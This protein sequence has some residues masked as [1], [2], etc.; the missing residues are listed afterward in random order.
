MNQALLLI[1]Q[2]YLPMLSETSDNL[3]ESI[4]SGGFDQVIFASGRRYKELPVEVTP[5]APP[6]Y[7]PTRYLVE[8]PVLGQRVAI[9]GGSFVGMELGRTLAM[10]GSLDPDRLF[11]LM[12]YGIESDETLHQM[13]KTTDRQVAIF[14]RGKLGAG[15]EVSIAK[16]GF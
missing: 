13:L 4:L 3:S 7:S 2:K 11:Y 1:L 16:N 5:D 8:K 10:T 14:E 12:R 15:Y 6:V 9:I